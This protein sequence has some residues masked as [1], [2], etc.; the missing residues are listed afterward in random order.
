LEKARSLLLASEHPTLDVSPAHSNN[1]PAVHLLTWQQ[2]LRK[3]TGIDVTVC[4]RCGANL[5]R[6]P[7][8]ENLTLSAFLSLSSPILNSS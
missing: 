8:P 5:L 7:L 2:L 3:L 4:P 1:T 6:L